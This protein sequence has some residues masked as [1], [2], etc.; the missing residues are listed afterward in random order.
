MTGN[1][2]W[3]REGVTSGN[4]FRWSPTECNGEQGYLNVMQFYLF[5][6]D[7]EPGRSEA[8][9]KRSPKT[10]LDG[11]SVQCP[12]PISWCGLSFTELAFNSPSSHK[13]YTLAR[14]S[15]SYSGGLGRVLQSLKWLYCKPQ[16]LSLIPGT[17]KLRPAAVV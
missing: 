4:S 7:P 12:H 8:Y 11:M 10:F 14:A 1:F 6:A 17:S 9:S 2:P 16:D 13:T 15:E 5:T 3:K